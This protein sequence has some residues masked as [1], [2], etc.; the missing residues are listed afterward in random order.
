MEFA[1]VRADRLTAGER[2]MLRSAQARAFA[3]LGRV[4]ETTWK[5]IKDADMEFHRIRPIEEKPWMRY[6]DAAQHQGDTGHA[7]FDL[8]IDERLVGKVIDGQVSDEAVSATYVGEA[9]TRLAG[10]VAGHTAAY[11]RSRA[12]SGIKLA[13]LTMVAGDPE[14]AAEIGERA[15][16]DAGTVRSRRAQDDMRE[17]TRFARPHERRTSA[18]PVHPHGRGEQSARSAR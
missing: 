7:V 10:A 6:Y 18:R 16:A 14:E 2:A 8:A 15:V 9:S 3:K 11:V 5:A 12:I 1:L 4:S 17:L 13:S